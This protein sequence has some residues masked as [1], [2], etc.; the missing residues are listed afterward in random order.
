MEGNGGGEFRFLIV[1]PENGGIWDAIRFGVLRDKQSGA[2]FLQSSSY[3]LIREELHGVSGRGDGDGDGEDPKHIWVIF[4]SIVVRKLLTLFRKPLEWTGYLVE[5]ILNLISLNGTF[6]AFLYK[7]FHG[8]LVMPQRGSETYISAIGH[9]DGRIDLS[10]SE[11]PDFWKTNVPL[12]PGNR[13]LMDL[14]M[15]ASK[16]AYENENVIRNVVNLHW[17]VW[18]FPVPLHFA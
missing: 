14:C 4:V 1:K 6:F 10:K 11:D 12:E 16:L 2:K 18:S 17:R 9:L 8:Q 7:L 5:F 3:G 15:V 13:A